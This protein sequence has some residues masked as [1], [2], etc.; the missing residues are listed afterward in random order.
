MKNFKPIPHNAAL[1]AVHFAY[2]K[3]RPATEILRA[4]EN[5][6]RG[7]S[8]CSCGIWFFHFEEEQAKILYGFVTTSH[9]ILDCPHL[10]IPLKYYYDN[11]LPKINRSHLDEPACSWSDVVQRIRTRQQLKASHG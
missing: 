5:P 6:D 8:Q 7:L 9:L 2:G 10:V 4:K 1:C 3:H 11:V